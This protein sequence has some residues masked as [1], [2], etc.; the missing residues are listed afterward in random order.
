MNSTVAALLLEKEA[1]LR[2]V[3][4][5]KQT[6]SWLVFTPFSSQDLCAVT[7]TFCNATAFAE[8]H[9]LANAC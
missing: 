9:C 8:A 3:Y 6:E 2:P 5:A 1:A 4:D 7:V